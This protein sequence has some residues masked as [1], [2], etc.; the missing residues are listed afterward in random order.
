[1]LKELICKCFI[2]FGSLSTTRCLM[3]GVYEL[4]IPVELLGN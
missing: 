4:E 3:P 2:G 1:M